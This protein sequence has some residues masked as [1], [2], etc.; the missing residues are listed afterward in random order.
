ME[1]TPRRTP[2]IRELVDHYLAHAGSSSFDELGKRMHA[3]FGLGS[4]TAIHAWSTGRRRPQ[5][6][7]QLDALRAVVGCLCLEYSGDV[8][9]RA[10]A[11]VRP[12]R[13]QPSRAQPSGLM[14]LKRVSAAAVAESDIVAYGAGSA[15][16]FSA[17]V[18]VTRKVEDRLLQ[19]LTEPSVNAVVGEAGHGKTALLWHLHR[20]LTQ[21][22]TPLL[23]PASVLVHGAGS[24]EP[25]LTLGLETIQAAIRE[26]DQRHERLVLLVDTLDLLLNDATRRNL[27]SD[28]L[29]LAFRT[30]TR[31]VVTSRPMEVAH[32]S[33]AYDDEGP[34]AARALRGVTLGGYDRDERAAAINAY[35]CAFFPVGAR[36]SSI[37][38]ELRVC[39][40][41]C[42]G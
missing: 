31:T 22:A 9:K 14:L 26:A 12:A 41:A 19:R 11:P 28:L 1:G 17:G 8:I 24:H 20:Q 15:V 32:L 5:R 2:T 29:T 4:R 25:P 7:E 27:V 16:R 10:M 34:V 39:G 37:G 40:A 33:I 6:P 38:A 42:R 30:G 21:F 18:Y 13:R 23:L 36:K 3:R 35:A